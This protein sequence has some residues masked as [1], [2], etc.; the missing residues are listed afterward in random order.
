MLLYVLSGIG[1]DLLGMGAM[2][3]N[4]LRLAVK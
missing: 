2:I 3:I 1:I 4:R